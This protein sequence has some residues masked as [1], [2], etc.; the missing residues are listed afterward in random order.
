MKTEEEQ[1][2]KKDTST[3]PQDGTLNLQTGEEQSKKKEASTSL[4]SCFEWPKLKEI[5]EI[6]L[7]P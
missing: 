1:S 6:H 3:N 5:K 7:N 4:Q 2:K